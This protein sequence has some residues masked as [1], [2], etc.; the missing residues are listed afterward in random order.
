MFRIMSISRNV[1]LLMNSKIRYIDIDT[2]IIHYTD[3][4]EYTQGYD[5]LVHATTCMNFESIL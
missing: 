2:D 5:V 4:E 3:T 1:Q